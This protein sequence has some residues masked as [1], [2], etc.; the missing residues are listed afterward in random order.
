MFPDVHRRKQ[1]WKTPLPG[2]LPGVVVSWT[3][4]LSLYL[5]VQFTVYANAYRVA[6]EPCGSE[7]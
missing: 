4:N 6:L 3:A 5:Q 2:H 1:A 7:W